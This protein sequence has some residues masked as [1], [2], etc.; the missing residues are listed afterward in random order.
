MGDF[1]R[2]LKMDRYT[3]PLSLIAVLL[4]IL[5]A[6]LMPFQFRFRQFSLESYFSRFTIGPNSN[7]D[8]IRNILLFAPLGFVL[9]AILDQRGWS[10]NRIRL[11][12]FCS[13][14][15]LTLTVESLQQFLPGRQ[16]SVT[17]LLANTIGAMVGLACFRFWRKRHAVRE[18]LR[19][20]VTEPRK[21]LAAL[22]IYVLFLLVVANSLV[23]SARVYSWDSRYHLMLGNEWTGDRPWVGALHDLV[24]FNEALEINDARRILESPELS[25]KNTKSLQAY[26]PLTGD[27]PY[28]DLAGKQ[29]DLTWQEMIETNSD[30][31]GVNFGGENWLATGYAVPDLFEALEDTSQFSVRLT[32]STSEVGQYGPARLLSISEDPFFRNLMFGQEHED[33][34]IRFRSPLTGDNGITPQFLF[35]DFF[36]ESTPIDFVVI[37]DGLQIDLVDARSSKVRSIELVPGI[38]FYAWYQDLITTK[39]ASLS[40]IVSGEFY[41]WLYRLLFYMVVLLPVGILL[42][43]PP[44]GTWS[45]KEHLILV[46]CCLIFVPFLLELALV[47]RSGQEIRPLNI[48][49]SVIFIAVIAWIA[50]PLVVLIRGLLRKVRTLHN[51]SPS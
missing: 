22:A 48:G 24:I 33:L 26:Y 9:G 45:K 20:A 49:I 37:Y 13:G 46:L 1:N 10:K 5:F 41:D 30:E 6:T 28:P 38:A 14:L 35:P 16:P 8:F 18:W 39:E 25:L 32:A 11:V 15:L 23:S 12:V 50:P 40:Q 42:A 51:S 27:N 4:V 2:R 7:F 36:D 17:D 34:I 21:I 29:P 47:I 44:G 31:G 19:V 3:A 43:L